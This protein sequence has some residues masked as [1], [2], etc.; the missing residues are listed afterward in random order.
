MDYPEGSPPVPT[1]NFIFSSFLVVKGYRSARDGR[2]KK[3]KEKIKA[4]LPKQAFLFLIEREKKKEKRK[5]KAGFFLKG[6]KEKEK[7]C[8]GARPRRALGGSAPPDPPRRLLCKN[9]HRH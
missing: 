8:L 2:Q 9:Q 7:G 5:I 4:G 6:K 1:E 3:R